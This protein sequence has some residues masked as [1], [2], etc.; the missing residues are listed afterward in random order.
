M[1]RGFIYLLAATILALV[2]VAVFVPGEL[3]V[4][5][6]A[7]NALLLPDLANRV[8]DVDRVDI[9]TAGDTVVATLKKAADYWQLEQMKGYQADWP[10][11]QRLLADLATARVVE[12]KTDKPEYY[13]R[14]G[15]E[16][17]ASEDAGS[18]LVRLSSGEETTGV[19]IGRRA[20]GRPGQYVRLQDSVTSA[21]LDRTLDV[22][23]KQLDWVNKRIIDISASEVAEVE[24]IHPEGGRVLLTKIS[25]D[26]T[27]FDL[28][29]LPPDREIRSS[30]AVN[31]L[32]S[33]LSLLD[34]ESVRPADSV[35][36][37][38]AV[39]MRVL[40]FSG[41]EIMAE[42]V[43]LGEDNL[44]RLQASNPAA[45]VVKD[46]AGITSDDSVEQR[47]AQDVAKMVTDINQRVNGWAYAI[48]RYKFEAMVKTQEDILKPVES[49]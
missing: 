15:V 47:A 6:T 1:K 39:R 30:W 48:A 22:P 36:W 37:N 17:V 28:V 46:E 29:G 40:M 12:V 3:S 33:A 26:Q 11:L 43:E 42:M 9:I 10:K 44:V 49:S 20:Q 31:S 16:D 19:L 2:A 5:D 18:V 8:N 23:T 34:L 7:A 38:A 25:A 35:D 32:G 45:A 41:L 13:V 14:L 24:I 21:L 27:D 4:E